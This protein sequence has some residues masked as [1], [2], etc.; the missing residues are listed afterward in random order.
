MSKPQTK[1]LHL[2]R[3][4]LDT[5]YEA[6]ALLETEA[7]GFDA[8]YERRALRRINSVNDRLNAYRRA[9]WGN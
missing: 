5:L 8:D 6:L 7:D 1:P 4:Q 3:S 2:T 9:K